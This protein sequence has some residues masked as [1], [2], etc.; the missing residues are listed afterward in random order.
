MAE[1]EE[2]EQLALIVDSSP[3]LN[4]QLLLCKQYLVHV[5]LHVEPQED[6]EIQCPPQFDIGPQ[7]L[8]QEFIHTLTHTSVHVE[9]PQ[10][11]P[12]SFKQPLSQLLKH[13][14]EHPV[15]LKLLLLQLPVQDVQ[16]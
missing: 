14:P 12:Q 5:L 6:P 9:L 7:P 10:P 4:P 11:T 16:P 2:D 15:E 1:Q 3:Q 8:P 13:Q